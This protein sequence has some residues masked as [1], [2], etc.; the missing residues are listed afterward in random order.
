MMLLDGEIEMSQSR[1]C[2]CLEK[3]LNLDHARHACLVLY[4]V[5]LHLDG[6]ANRFGDAVLCNDKL[7]YARCQP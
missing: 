2:L 5:M 6:Y 1:V 3:G 4:G 7:L